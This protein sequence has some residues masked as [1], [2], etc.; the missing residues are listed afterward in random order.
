MTAYLSTLLAMA[1]ISANNARP[2]WKD[3]VKTADFAAGKAASS[4][5]AMPPMQQ[6]AQSAYA[7]PYDP[8]M[9]TGYGSYAGGAQV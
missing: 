3:T 6:Q 5:Y 7:M 8:P 4:G 1:I 2:V 9:A